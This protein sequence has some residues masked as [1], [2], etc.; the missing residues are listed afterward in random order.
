MDTI[1]FKVHT[2]YDR[3]DILKMEKISVRKFRK[4][5]MLVTGIAFLLYGAFMVYKMAAGIDDSLF[6][7][8][9][10][11]D[12]ILLTLLAMGFGISWA[13][14]YFQ[15]GKIMKVSQEGKLKANFYFHEKYFQ[16]GWGGEYSTVSYRQ[17]QEF[18]NLE[19]TFYLKADQ[20][21]YWIKKEDFVIGTW[22]AFYT[23]MLEK[24]DCRCLK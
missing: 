6:F 24:S 20:V 22:E 9:N 15:T 17:I 2:Q 16:Y 12:W 18:M 19:H 5:N 4:K 13:F 21:S 10:I 8:K 3:K 23:F 7:G 11:L 14:P 1:K